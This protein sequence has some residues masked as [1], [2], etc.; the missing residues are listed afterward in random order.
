MPLNERA[1]QA[2]ITAVSP[3]I[4]YS[5]LSGFPNLHHRAEL[6]VQGLTA[7]FNCLAPPKPVRPPSFFSNLEPWLE[8]HR[9][10]QF[11]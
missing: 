11:F 7:R 1:I 8:L 5:L 4:L 2:I 10:L 3:P 6:L 9:L